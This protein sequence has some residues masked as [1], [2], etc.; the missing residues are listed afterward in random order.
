MR[1]LC[2]SA[3]AFLFVAVFAVAAGAA[4]DPVAWSGKTSPD[5]A[6]ARG[7]RFTVALEARIQPGWHLYSLDQPD[8]GPVATEISL[9]TGQP[10]S[11]AAAIAAPK[12]HVVFDPNFNMRVGFY[13][14][15]VQFRVP[16]EVGAAAQAGPETLYIQTRYQCCNDKMCLP[17]KSVTVPIAI[18]VR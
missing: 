12:P 4:E 2:I 7:A 18:Q 6:L 15:K 9:P 5:K 14:E 13:L 17:P 16:L 1:R 11:F 8:G 10:F 3:S